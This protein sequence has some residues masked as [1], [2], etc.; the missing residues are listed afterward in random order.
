MKDSV[1]LLSAVSLTTGAACTLLAM[2]PILRLCRKRKLYDRPD[3]RKIH[4]KAIPRLGGAA[5]MPGVL[6]AVLAAH[7]CMVAVGMEMPGP[8]PSDA[9]IAV[10]ICITF[11][12]GL[13]DDIRGITPLQKLAAQT[14]AALTV[15]LSGL[16][17]GC[18]EDAGIHACDMVGVVLTLFIIIYMNNAVNFIDGIDGLCGC[19]AIMAMAVFFVCF[20]ERGT[21]S[22]AF[23]AAGTAGSVMAFLRYNMFGNA[24][25]GSKIFMGDT[26]SLTLGFI[27]CVMGL[28]L[29]TADMA[30]ETPNGGAI[31]AVMAVAAIPAMDL[32]RVALRRLRDRKNILAADKNHIHHKLMEA[33]LSQ[34][35]ALIVIMSAMFTLLAAN[36]LLAYV[37]TIAVIAA[38]DIILFSCGNL[39]LNRIIKRRKD[40]K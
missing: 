14:A 30:R 10:G 40:M 20:V 34:R 25:K 39:L 31:P 21:Y 7:V 4:R 22:C 29:V 33:G 9:I 3:A 23:A 16:C 36:S 17:L 2:P 8:F 13:Y 37:T 32:S 19:F 12:A 1:L 15:P 26:G 11:C 6:L 27:I 38:T 35:R 24:D 5:F 28:R 18:P